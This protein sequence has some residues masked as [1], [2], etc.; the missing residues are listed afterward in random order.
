[1]QLFPN[2]DWK[3]HLHNAKER[4][5][6]DYLCLSLSLHVF[7]NH[8]TL[9]KNIEATPQDSELNTQFWLSFNWQFL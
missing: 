3:V 1:M 2:I 6:I 9:D 4:E 7:W 8:E 5:F